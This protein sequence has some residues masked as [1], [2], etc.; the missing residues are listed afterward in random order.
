MQTTFLKGMTYDKN[1]IGPGSEPSFTL[2]LKKK[3][4]SV[5]V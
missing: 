5:D 4:C 1:K 3:V 2:K